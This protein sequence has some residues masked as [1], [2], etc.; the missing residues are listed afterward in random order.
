MPLKYVLITVRNILKL[1]IKTEIFKT[2][3]AAFNAMKTELYNRLKMDG[4]ENYMNIL[5]DGIELSN[6]KLNENDAY[7]Y[8][9][10]A[11]TYHHWKIIEV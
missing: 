10:C 2:K 6:A 7:I 9:D 11:E 1:E 3:E 8:Q 4:A 5:E